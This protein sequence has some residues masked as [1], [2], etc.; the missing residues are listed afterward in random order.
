MNL[1]LLFFREKIIKYLLIFD[2]EKEQENLGD[3]IAKE[4]AQKKRA[5]EDKAPRKPA[6][7]KPVAK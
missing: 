2:D 5:K 6:A 4:S 7:K 1:D 3:E